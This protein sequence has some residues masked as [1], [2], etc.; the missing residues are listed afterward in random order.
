MKHEIY[1]GETVTGKGIGW[2]VKAKQ[3]LAGEM[4]IKISRA[5][6][7]QQ[8]EKS[9]KFST[10]FLPVELDKKNILLWNKI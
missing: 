3:Q 9:F 8:E 2:V 5:V 4:K 10:L 1:V 6:K 7:E